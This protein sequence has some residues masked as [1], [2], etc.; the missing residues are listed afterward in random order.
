MKRTLTLLLFLLIPAALSFSYG[1]EVPAAESSE[2]IDH[3][4]YQLKYNESWEQAQWV[5][6]ELTREELTGTALRR[7]NFRPDKLIASGSA[8]LSDYRGSGWDRGHL[9][10][11]ADL[12]MTKQSMSESFYLSNISPQLPAFNRGIWLELEACVRTWAWE[13]ESLYIIT[14]P[15]ITAN[16]V[17]TIGENKV[18]VPDFFYKVILDATGDEKKTVGFILPN[19]ESSLPLSD[20]AVSVDVLE[21]I[22]GEDFYPL[23]PDDLESTLEAEYDITAWN[24]KMFDFREH[25]SSEEQITSEPE[26]LYWINSNSETRHNPS[27]KYYGHT[28]KGYFTDD[29]VGNICG[30]CGG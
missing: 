1:L 3:R 9:I 29:E 22:T 14:G 25:Y 2:I 12:K 27:C 10:P 20:F 19:Q 11:A 28:K 13:N 7:N 6:Y 4:W 8:E 24:F 17:N 15:V 18:A 21:Q 30:F 23:L 16:A 26:Y 5:A